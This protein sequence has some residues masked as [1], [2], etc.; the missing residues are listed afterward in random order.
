MTS[1]SA[2]SLN[3]IVVAMPCYNSQT[4]IGETLENVLGQTHKEFRVVVYDDGSTDTSPD[5]VRS[6][7]RRDSRVVLHR[8]EIN[9]GRPQARNALLALV[10]DAILAWQDADDLWH[11]TKLAKQV[12]FYENKY[13]QCSDEKIA[14]VSSLERCR[15][16]GEIDVDHRYLSKVL[17]QG[18][19]GELHPP[20]VYD[21]NFIC[22]DKYMSFPFYLQSTFARATHFIEAGGF[23]PELPWYEDLDMGIKLLGIGI[24]IFGLKSEVALAYYFSG[25]PRLAPD[26]VTACLKRIYS[27]NKD[28]M[29][30][31]GIDV[32]YDFSL[33]NLTLLFLGMIRKREFSTALEILAQNSTFALTRS[34]LKEL[35]ISNVEVLQKALRASESID[36]YHRIVSSQALP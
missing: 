4:T 1:I 12:S 26:I 20:H 2:T 28:F 19:Y 33:R 14:V 5:I 29:S 32:Q 6:F 9:Q 16:K 15:P 30:A 22:S 21:L 24:K 13:Q 8:N 34:E 23:D 3:D 17:S 10:P 7:E 25:A 27:N 18:Y 35:F 36:P 11:P 31:S